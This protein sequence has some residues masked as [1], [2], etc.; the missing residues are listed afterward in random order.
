[1]ISTDPVLQVHFGNYFSAS[2]KSIMF[3]TLFTGIHVG[4]FAFGWIKLKRDSDLK[5]F[6]DLGYSVLLSRSAGLVLCFDCTILM[7]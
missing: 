2:L 3:W 6:T 4:L 7:Y 1:M 5:I